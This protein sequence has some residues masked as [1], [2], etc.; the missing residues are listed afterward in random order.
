MSGAGE[1][2]RTWYIVQRWQEY[3]GEAR[4]NL[5][6]IVAVGSFY[7]IHLLNYYQVNLGL[8]QLGE[9]GGGDRQFHLSITALA[10]AWTMLALAVHLCLRQQFFPAWLKFVSTG[11]DLLL[12]T[13]VLYVAGGPRSPLVAGYF[14]VIALATL[15]FNLPLVRFATLA[16]MAGYLCLLGCDRWPEI[17]RPGGG[18]FE[19]LPR[20]HQLMVLLAIG[21]TGVVLGQVV[22]RA[23]VLAE[24][25]AARAGEREADAR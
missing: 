7:A 11:G 21:L 25:F 16:A 9:T 24:E 3:A 14:L 4:A 2:G 23:P 12:L 19:R 20:Y 15:R 8:L 17:F 10:V 18:A 13:S 6:R 5:L 1:G 22:R